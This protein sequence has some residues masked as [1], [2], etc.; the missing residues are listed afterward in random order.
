MQTYHGGG[1][2]RSDGEY[3]SHNCGNYGKKI[4]IYVY[5]YIVHGGWLYS[6]GSFSSSLVKPCQT[7][8]NHM[9]CSFVGYHRDFP[10]ARLLSLRQLSLNLVGYLCIAEHF[11]LGQ[12]MVKERYD[13]GHTIHYNSIS[14]EFMITPQGLVGYTIHPTLDLLGYMIYIYVII[15]I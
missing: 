13:N 1:P 3:K 11:F 8:S 4:N 6:H 2:Q 12:T 5:N 10:A 9:V 7:Q 14:N 15:R